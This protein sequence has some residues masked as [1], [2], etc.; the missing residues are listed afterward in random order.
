MY[1][2]L[3]AFLF[4]I[5]CSSKRKDNEKS[6][7]LFVVVKESNVTKSIYMVTLLNVVLIKKNPFEI[8]DMKLHNQS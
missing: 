3:R 2:G 6:L 1:F 7:N 5:L 8:C 4:F